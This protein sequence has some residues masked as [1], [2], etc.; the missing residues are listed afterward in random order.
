MPANELRNIL[1]I[2]ETVA[3]EF[4][5]SGNGISADTY[6]TVCSFLNRF[7]GDIY[8]G[9][10]DSGEV[11]GLPPKAAP[12]MVKNFISAVNN[13]DII[14]PTVY[15]LPKI[16][17]Y[18]GKTLIHIHIHPSA[19]VHTYKRVI[20]D[21]MGDSDVKVTATG[22]TAQMFIRKQKIY[23]E[24]KV[25]PYV[26]KKH[27]RLDLLPRI[28]QMA[29]NRDNKHPW[30]D[31]SDDELLQSAGLIGEDLETGQRRVFL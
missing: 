22:Q 11:I 2:G 9:I 17:E 5:R 13:P 16:I 28:R 3:V 21:R 7:G 25:Y 31:L 20:F 27:L 18:E 23:T 14:S 29:V 30:K 15:L 26:T 8:L 6:E 24:K 12:D 1:S 19:E 10:E 4:K